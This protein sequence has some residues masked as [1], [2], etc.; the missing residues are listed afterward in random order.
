MKEHIRITIVLTENAR[1]FAGMT[2]IR[3]LNPFEE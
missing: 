1:D 3:A 2:E